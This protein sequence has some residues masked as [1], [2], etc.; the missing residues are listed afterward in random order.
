MFVRA[1]V[2]RHVGE[3]GE[4]AGEKRG[5]VV[6]SVRGAHVCAGPSHFCEVCSS[7]A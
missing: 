4:K 6:G 2:D 1:G 7:E 3:C 5:G